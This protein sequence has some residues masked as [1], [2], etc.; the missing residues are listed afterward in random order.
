MLGEVIELLLLVHSLSFGGKL[1]ACAVDNDPQSATLRAILP[2]SFVIISASFLRVSDT[3][4]EVTCAFV[5]AECEGS[6]GV[7]VSFVATV[8]NADRTR[9]WILRFASDHDPASLL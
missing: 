6:S 2:D 5:K 9:L 3:S 8:S 1:Q 4:A 7:F